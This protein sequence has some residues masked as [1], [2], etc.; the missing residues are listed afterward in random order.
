MI[1]FRRDHVSRIRIQFDEKTGIFQQA[2]SI[3][4]R[5]TIIR[6]QV[7]E[8][9]K[10]VTGWRIVS[11]PYNLSDILPPSIT[12]ITPVFQHEG[13]VYVELWSETQEIK[14]M[15]DVLFTLVTDR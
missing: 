5:Q 10:G 2:L 11:Q 4:T 7:I 9:P 8:L 3:P 13:G 6:I 12:D 14:G 1:N 15:L